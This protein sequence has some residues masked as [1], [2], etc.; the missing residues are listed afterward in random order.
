MAYPTLTPL[1]NAIRA[2]YVADTDLSGALDDLYLEDSKKQSATPVYPFGIYSYVAGSGIVTAGSY[3]LKEPLIQFSLF[4]DDSNMATLDTAYGYLLAEFN[5][6]IINSTRNYLFKWN[7]DRI[8]K[9]DN[10]WH[11]ICEYRVYDH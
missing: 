7:S 10:I 1:F 8:Y 3:I 4:D 5:D 11:H 6:K 2:A 9:V